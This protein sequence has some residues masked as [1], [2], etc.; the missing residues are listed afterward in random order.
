MF[1]PELKPPQAAILK[2]YISTMKDLYG[3]LV[4]EHPTTLFEAQE[5]ACE[6]EEN[7]AT[8]LIQEEENPRRLFR[9]IRLMT[10]FHQNFSQMSEFTYKRNERKKLI[11]QHVS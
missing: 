4:R 11:G 8:S 1:S 5:R 10:L 2:L 3:G 9:L 7:L 6:I